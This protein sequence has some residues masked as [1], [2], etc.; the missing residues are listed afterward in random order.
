MNTDLH[1]PEAYKLQQM[2]HV[3]CIHN[4]NIRQYANQQIRQLRQYVF[5][6]TRK[7]Q[8]ASRRKKVGFKAFIRQK[9]KENS[10][11]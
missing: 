6:E 9:H 4:S 3:V 2:S 5:Q 1:P 11:K 7:L 8:K 10:N